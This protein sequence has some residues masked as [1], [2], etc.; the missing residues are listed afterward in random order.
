MTSYPELEVR[1]AEP[2]SDAGWT[3]ALA[4][5]SA[6]RENPLTV[7][8]YCLHVMHVNVRDVFPPTA[9]ATVVKPERVKTVGGVTA[10]VGGHAVDVGGVAD[11]VGG[12]GE[13][14]D[15]E[16]EEEE[17]EEEENIEDNAITIEQISDWLTVNFRN[18]I[19]KKL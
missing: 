3:E 17:E 14:D 19:D 13:D 7:F 1:H 8:M 10:A 2:K 6:L 18:I 15:G 5:K 12:V 4:L 16:E 11:E 9:L